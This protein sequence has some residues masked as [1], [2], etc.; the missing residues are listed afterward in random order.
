[1]PPSCISSFG[2]IYLSSQENEM[3]SLKEIVEYECLKISQELKDVRAMQPKKLADFLSRK[4]IKIII[5]T[6]IFDEFF[7]KKRIV[8]QYLKFLPCFMKK[9]Q[10]WEKKYFS[11]ENLNLIEKNEFICSVALLEMMHIHFSY[12]YNS[13]AIDDIEV[14]L[15]FLMVT[16]MRSF[17]FNSLMKVCF[18][19]IKDNKFTDFYFDYEEMK[20]FSNTTNFSIDKIISYNNDQK[21]F[22]LSKTA[23]RLNS[24]V[25]FVSECSQSY[26]IFL[27]GEA[28]SGKSNF[29]HFFSKKILQ[30]PI[31]KQRE[32]SRSNII[33]FKNKI[34]FIIYCKEYLKK[35]K[36]QNL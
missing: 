23:F 33:L 19:N 2:K 21:I 6:N 16:L 7:H 34:L 18:E 5:N 12:V 22:W 17:P 25:K 15:K 29:L 1:M 28:G 13:N 32:I 4:I 35:Q 10:D 31:V 11:N 30:I 14:S 3:I 36:I 24:F 8:I 9:F 26:K 27:F 20:Y